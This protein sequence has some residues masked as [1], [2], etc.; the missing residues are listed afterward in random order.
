MNKYTSYS[1][2]LR[3]LKQCNDHKLKIE[4]CNI[5]KHKLN[6]LK[7]MEGGMI[8]DPMLLDELKMKLYL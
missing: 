2:I 3:L 1:E 5:L 6:S 8:L 4:V 7:P